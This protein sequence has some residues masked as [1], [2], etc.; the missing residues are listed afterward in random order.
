MAEHMRIPMCF[1]VSSVLWIRS[2]FNADPDRAFLGQCG[3]VSR[4]K[5][6]HF[7]KT[8]FLSKFA[9]FLLFLGLHQGRPS[10]RQAFSPQKRTSNMKPHF[11][12]FPLVI[13][14]PLRSVSVL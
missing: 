2:G 13:F 14:L 1:T 9:I 10:Y 8:F 6:A 3:F 7:K 11:F 4:V 5:I 12:L